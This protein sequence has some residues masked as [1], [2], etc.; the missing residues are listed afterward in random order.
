MI[1]AA[2]AFFVACNP[3]AATVALAHD[4][5]T[6]RPIP[7]IAGAV[8]A[9]VALVLA[10][11]ASDALLDVLDLNLGTY[12]VGAGAVLVAAG[13]RWLVVGAPRDAIEPETDLRLAGFVAF[14]TLLT[15]AAAALAVSV[16]A[17]EGVAVVAGAAAISIV[18]GG[19]GVYLR[20]Q[21][22]T[23]LAVALVRLIAAG[24]VVVGVDLVVD[25]LMTL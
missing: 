15:P 1:A 17:E 9:L 11:A 24:T 12:R 22:P 14:P 4:R 7:V 13:L 5:R 10:A 18:L 6:D 20:R 19:L 8:A 16:G 23:A 25:G 21:V 2:I 3:A